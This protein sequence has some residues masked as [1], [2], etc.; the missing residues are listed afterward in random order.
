[1][2]GFIE[3]LEAEE[4]YATPREDLKRSLLEW[5]VVWVL[6]T[7]GGLALVDDAAGWL[8]VSLIVLLAIVIRAVVTS[9]WMTGRLSGGAAA[10]LKLASS[11][12]VVVLIC[13]GFLL[14]V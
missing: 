1:M 13:G 2:R 9:Y 5:A 7:V 11:A 10:V 3:W 6:V 4:R 8:S 14:F 12:L